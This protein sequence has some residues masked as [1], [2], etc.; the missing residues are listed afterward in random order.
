MTKSVFKERTIRNMK[1]C[2]D[3]KRVVS[4]RPLEKLLEQPS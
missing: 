3:L 2:F 4:G 1:D